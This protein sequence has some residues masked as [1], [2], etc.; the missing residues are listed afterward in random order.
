MRILL[1]EC[2]PR[3]LAG[4]RHFQPGEVRRLPAR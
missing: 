3:P 2:L 1:D 4:L